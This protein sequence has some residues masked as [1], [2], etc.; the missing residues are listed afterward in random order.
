M[1]GD[2]A[3]D[4]DGIATYAMSDD[5]SDPRVNLLREDGSGDDYS[6]AGGDLQTAAHLGGFVGV[7]AGQIYENYAETVACD[8]YSM[9]YFFP[10]PA[11]A[12]ANSC[13]AGLGA[14]ALLG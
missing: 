4:C 14:I 5:G 10:A 13:S 11:G 2:T 12:G 1:T 8:V 7:S 9:G 3:A 6:A